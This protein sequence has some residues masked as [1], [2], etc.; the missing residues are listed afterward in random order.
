MKIGTA[1][2]AVRF[3][4][5]PCVL[6]KRFWATLAMALALS[7]PSLAI[8]VGLDRFSITRNGAA[9]FTDNFND[10]IPP[11]SAPNFLFNPNIA[12]SYGIQG[13]IP[14]GA[15]SNGVLQFDS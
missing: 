15:E 1:F 3:N 10:G 2:K 5:K 4:L 8:V 13:T 9:F 11:P 14:N 12:A 7:S 6:S